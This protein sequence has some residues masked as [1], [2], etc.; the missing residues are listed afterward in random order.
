MI[1]THSIDSRCVTGPENILFEGASLHI[2][3]RKFVQAR[4]VKGLKINPLKKNPAVKR[5][6]HLGGLL[7]VSK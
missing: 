2:S 6:L 3:A 1:T 7:I 5:K 4:S